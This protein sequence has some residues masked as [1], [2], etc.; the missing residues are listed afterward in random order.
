[1]LGAAGFLVTVST[2]A[3]AQDAAQAV[4]PNAAYVPPPLAAPHAKLDPSAPSP[5]DFQP[6]EDVLRWTYANNPT[7]R[8]ARAELKATHEE[9]PQAQAGYKP[10]VAADADA[11]WAHIESD[12]DTTADGSFSKQVGLTATQPLYRGGRTVAGV[13]SAESRIA[14]QTAILDATEQRIMRDVATAYMNVVRDQALL[15]LR[16]NN[17]TVI[18][19]QLD[20]TH[21][22]FEVGELTRTDVSQAEARLARAEADRTQAL[23]NLRTSRSVYEQLVGMPAGGLGY[24][25]LSFTI[26]D[27]LDA[28]IAMAE[29][30]NPS[31]I[32]SKFVHKASKSDIDGI[33]GELLPEV[34]LF[35]SIDKEYDPQPGTF[36]ETT[37]SAVGVTA[38]WPLYTGG[39]TRSRVRQ[40]KYVSSQ[41]Y[42]T[43]LETVRQA[44]QD[45][46]ENWE[47]LA[48]AK[49]E[50]DS[51]EAQ[52]TAA[53][54]AREGVYQEAELG[55]RT[56]L[57]TLDADQE[58]LDAQ[59]A[60]VTARRNE[61]VANFYLAAT[62]GLLTPANL[63]FSEI[64]E[65][66]DAHLAYTEGKI[67]GMDVDIDDKGQ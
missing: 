8:A 67:L 23:G 26:P 41:R 65:D 31:V 24:P 29:Q 61:T 63:G 15:D 35:G 12:P 20:A 50:I 13:D 14:A 2:F 46:V 5:K 22:R 27:T 40:A 55:S 10:T 45:T 60:L 38:S 32:A 6:L 3:M 28:A 25:K 48:A 47:T 18:K 1:M 58:Y 53:G 9:L 43:I 52:V 57:D 19:R 37:T 44:R 62:L 30:K 51:R 66:H 11:T 17:K 7:L 16:T 39:A 33:F 42:M 64:A 34:S 59:V 49:A 54:V 4:D 21:D 56:I 36:D